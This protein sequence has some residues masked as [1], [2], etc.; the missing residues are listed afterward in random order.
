MNLLL[1]KETAA[2]LKVSQATLRRWRKHG[3]GP[4]AIRVGPGTYRYSAEA[5]DAYISRQTS[6]AAVPNR[7]P[8]RERKR[9]L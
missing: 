8:E 4:P 6:S 2:Q 9:K 3:T 1:P 7:S 5:I